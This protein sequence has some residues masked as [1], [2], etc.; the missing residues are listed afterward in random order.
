MPRSGSLAAIGRV[1]HLDRRDH[2]ERVMTKSLS[3]AQRRG[4]Q[5]LDLPYHRQRRQNRNQLPPCISAVVGSLDKTAGISEATASTSP[6]PAETS[7][8]LAAIFDFLPCD[9]LPVGSLISA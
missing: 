3:S 2:G 6:L 4:I 1:Y 7:T 8:L 9:R 5:G